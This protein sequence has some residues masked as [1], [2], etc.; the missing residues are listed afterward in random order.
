MRCV[1]TRE[2]GKKNAVEILDLMPK[3]AMRVERE[4]REGIA[5]K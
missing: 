5:K 1:D 2:A 4:A 3:V